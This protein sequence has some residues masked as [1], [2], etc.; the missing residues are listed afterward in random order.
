[1]LR[2]Y[3]L[4]RRLDPR[5][6][7]LS[8]VADRTL[9]PSSISVLSLST[10]TQQ[11][12]ANGLPLAASD[13]NVNLMLYG[14]GLADIQRN[15]S[16]PCRNEYYLLLPCCWDVGY[17][18]SPARTYTLLKSPLNILNREY[19]QNARPIPGGRLLTLLRAL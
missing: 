1:M 10:I 18:D 13:H 11:I 14:T 5:L 3:T 16:P 19:T 15:I 2:Q 17:T 8:E 4:G 9:S 7:R 12:L 6:M